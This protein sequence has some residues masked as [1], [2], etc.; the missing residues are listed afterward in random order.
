MLRELPVAP[1]R[2]LRARR[3]A[4][5]SEHRRHGRGHRAGR[6][7]RRGRRRRAR[8]APGHPR[9]RARCAAST[10][11]SASAAPRPSRRSPTGRRRSAR[12]DVIAGPGSL[13]VQEAK[14]LVSGD[15][16]IDGFHGPSDVLVVATAGARRRRS[17]R[18]TCSRRPSTGRGRSWPP[19]RDDRALLD[20]VAR[21][22]RRGPG[23]DGA[24]RRSSQR[25][26]ARGRARLRRGLRA[27]APRARRGPRPRRSP[28]ACGAPAALFVGRESA[29]GLRRLRRRLEPLAADRRRGPLRLRRCRPAPSAGAWPRS[30]SAPRPRALRTRRRADRA[31][32]GLRAHAASMEAR[33]N[34][35]AMAPDDP[36]RRDHAR[37]A[38]T[39][40]APA[41]DPRRHRARGARDR[42]RLPGPHARPARP[43]R[44]AG[45]R[46]RRRAATSRPAA[47]T[48]PRTPASCSGRRSTG[49]SATAPGSRA[50]ATPS[51]RW[52]RRARRARSTSPGRPFLA[53]DADL[54]PPGVTGGFDHELVEEFFRAVATRADDDAPR[55]SRRAR[56]PT[57]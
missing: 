20:D 52:T 9:G 27:R 41:P 22:P 54:L 47:T 30:G 43:P 35:D 24:V 53:F 25:P 21:A 16:G 29:H 44:A 39:D 15:V 23:G 46:R 7:G 50:T 48:P 34:G 18:S 10:R 1:R 40:V 5:L 31:R 3:T 8:R 19:S 13:W 6:R 42:R 32:R 28:R 56:T 11:S 57:T 33:E 14:R 36:H 4:P 26:D 2:H 51:C 55:R 37:D 49:R 17:S 45:P 38:E 12:A